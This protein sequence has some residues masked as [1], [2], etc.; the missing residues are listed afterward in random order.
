MSSRGPRTFVLPVGTVCVAQTPP[1]GGMKTPMPPRTQLR[2]GEAAPIRCG[3]RRLSI[4]NTPKRSPSSPCCSRSR[5]RRRR[6][7][8]SVVAPSRIQNSPR[9]T[10]PSTVAPRRASQGGSSWGAP[11]DAQ[12]S[13]TLAVAAPAATLRFGRCRLPG[14]GRL[15]R[16]VCV[17]IE[18]MAIGARATTNHWPR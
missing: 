10:T 7:G 9:H 16:V 11:I 13:Q 1:T 3:L 6:D 17:M 4:H 18:L 15:N 14:R 12:S 5:S 2:R 8:P